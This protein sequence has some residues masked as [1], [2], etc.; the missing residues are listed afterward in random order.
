[1]QELSVP[2]MPVAETF[3]PVAPV[4]EPTG[5]VVPVVEEAPAP[6]VEVSPEA[7]PAPGVEA[8]PEVEPVS[9]PELDAAIARAN[10]LESKVNELASKL[11]AYQMTEALASANLPPEAA[12]LVQALYAAQG[13]GQEVGPW[14]SAGMKD[15]ASPLAVLK[16]L[17]AAPAPAT[18]DPRTTTPADDAIQ[19]KGSAKTGKP[20]PNFGS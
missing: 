5:E 11:V 19:A 18:P 16:M 6:E 14:L 12:P 2:D 1:M 17:K 3:A 10:E 15:K 7:E 4:E 9:N 20:V 8:A 13:Q